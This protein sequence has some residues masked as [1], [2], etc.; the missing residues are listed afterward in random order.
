[1]SQTKI[2][3]LPDSRGCNCNWDGL[4]AGPAKAWPKLLIWISIVLLNICQIQI[5]YPYQLECIPKAQNRA[6]PEFYEG[7]KKLIWPSPSCTHLNK[8]LWIMIIIYMAYWF[9]YC[10][11]WSCRWCSTKGLIGSSLWTQF[12]RPHQAKSWGKIWEQGLQLVCQTRRST[13]S[14]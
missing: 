9:G 8:I 11:L 2:K 7:Y 6:R 10:V 3:T 14:P 12:Q 13:I 5:G 4:G 1:M